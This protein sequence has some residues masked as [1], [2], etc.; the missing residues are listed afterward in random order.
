MVPNDEEKIETLMES[1]VLQAAGVK[2]WSP[3]LTSKVYS[4]ARISKV[5]KTTPAR[6]PGKI[7]H[8][9]VVPGVATPWY[10]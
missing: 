6:I 10:G 5:G 4:C 3:V 9:E 1:P 2:P 8:E 7:V